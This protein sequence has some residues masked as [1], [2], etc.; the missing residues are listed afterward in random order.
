[1]VMVISCAC[2]ELADQQSSCSWH[3]LSN[4]EHRLCV[5]IASK[6][7]AGLTWPEVSWMGLASFNMPV[8]ISGPCR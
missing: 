1:V 6:A 2:Q 5:V 7:T 4:Q 3:T 8:R